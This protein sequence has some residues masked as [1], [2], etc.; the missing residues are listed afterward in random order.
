VGSKIAQVAAKYL[1]PV[2]MEL[3]DKAAAIV[4]EEANLEEEAATCI[5]GG[6]CF[7]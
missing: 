4:L 1:K 2:P 7:R 3:G 5:F 6:Q